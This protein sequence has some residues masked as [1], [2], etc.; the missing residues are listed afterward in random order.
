MP[1]WVSSQGASEVVGRDVC[2]AQDAGE[3]ADF[4]RTVHRHYATFG[5]APHDDVAT[6]LPNLCEAETLKGFYDRHPEVRGSLGMRREAKHGDYG[7]SGREK[8]ELGEIECRRLLQIGNCFFDCFALSGSACL[9]VE[10]DVAAFFGGSKN[11]SQFHDNASRKNDLSQLSRIPD[12]D[13]Q[14]G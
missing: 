13:A 4:D 1:G 5:P 10:R 6:G 11:S 12:I 3:R 14:R 7:M 8:W 9:R 2:L